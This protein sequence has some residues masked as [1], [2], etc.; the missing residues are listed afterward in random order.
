[1]TDDDSLAENP[2]RRAIRAI[3]E[4]TKA[5]RVMEGLFSSFPKPNYSLL[6]IFERESQ[7][8]RRYEEAVIQ[9]AQQPAIQPPPEPPRPRKRRESSR[10]EEWKR[11]KECAACINEGRAA[12]GMKT[13]NKSKLA[14]AVIEKLEL[15]D[16]IGT[17]RKRL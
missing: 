9:L 16:D 1:M 5:T 7:R 6:E 2:A 3:D 17:V 8:K 14:L 11:W 13:M 10:A 4:L 15:H 12:K